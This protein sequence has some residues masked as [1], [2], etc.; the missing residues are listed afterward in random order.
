LNALE[1]PEVFKRNVESGNWSEVLSALERYA[2]EDGS[3]EELGLFDIYELL[4]YELVAL[5]ELSV[6]QLFFRSFKV[7]D[8]MK[9]RFPD[10]HLALEICIISKSEVAQTDL[11]G[12]VTSLEKRRKIVADRNPLAIRSALLTCV[13]Q[14]RFHC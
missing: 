13:L 3:K 10:R 7:F 4:F 6:A 1:H 2:W 9:E 8:R 11:W 14:G 5:K 12:S